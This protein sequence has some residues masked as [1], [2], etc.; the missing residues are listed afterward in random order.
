[1]ELDGGEMRKVSEDGSKI[2]GIEELR[3]PFLL[4]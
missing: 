4:R 3:V 1:M 2:R